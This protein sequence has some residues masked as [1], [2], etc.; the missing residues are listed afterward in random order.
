MEGHFVR[1][2]RAK[3]NQS[4]SA[5]APVSFIFCHS[6]PHACIRARGAGGKIRGGDCG[7]GFGCGSEVSVGAVGIAGARGDSIDSRTSAGRGGGS[8]AVNVAI[9]FFGASCANAGRKARSAA[10]NTS[11]AKAW[12]NARRVPLRV[13]TPIISAIMVFRSN[14]QRL[15]ANPSFIQIASLFE[16][17]WSRIPDGHVRFPCSPPG[18]QSNALAAPAGH[19]ARC[20]RVK[21]RPW[22]DRNDQS[23]VLNPTLGRR[24]G[25][26]K[27]ISLL[28]EHTAYHPFCS[29][30]V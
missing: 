1:Q 7:G 20:L 25:A 10:A 4:L 6:N 9:G 12:I 29:F 28:H 16:L 24:T 2:I 21:C 23:I 3:S 14:R 15:C 18:G 8:G 13:A 19:G 27:N 22:R 30:E 17:S 26:P 5:A 11:H